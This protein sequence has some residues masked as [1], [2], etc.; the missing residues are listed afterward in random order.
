MKRSVHT[1]LEENVAPIL[2]QGLEELLRVVEEDR[3]DVAAGKQ[4]DA[5]GTLPEEWLPFQA[6]RWLGNW[7]ME[8][9][10]LVDERN[11]TFQGP[12]LFRDM[13]PEEQLELGQI[14]MSPP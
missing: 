12:V 10:K 5:D 14:N 3:L 8:P 1:Y 9:A 4:W 6:L 13:S 2:R 7:L 11:T